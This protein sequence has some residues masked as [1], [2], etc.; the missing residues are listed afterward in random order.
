LSSNPG[1]HAFG[2]DHA[3]RGRREAILRPA[4]RRVGQSLRVIVR[5]A[6][7]SSLRAVSEVAK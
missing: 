5:K 6:G 7:T 1:L 2:I 3:M 4:L